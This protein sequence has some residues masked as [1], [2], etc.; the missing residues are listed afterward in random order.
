MGLD[1][2][3]QARSIHHTTTVC[4]AGQQWHNPYTVTQDNKV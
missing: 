2:T 4:H 1:S 3:L